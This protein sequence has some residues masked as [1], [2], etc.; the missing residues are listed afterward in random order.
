[1]MVQDSFYQKVPLESLRQTPISTAACLI[2]FFWT[3]S[4]RNNPSVANYTHLGAILLWKQLS[5]GTIFVR[6]NFPRGG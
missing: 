4:S 6:M 1:M 3:E 2:A 5:L